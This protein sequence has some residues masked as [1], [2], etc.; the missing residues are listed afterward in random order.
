[1]N[2]IW[3]LAGA[4]CCILLPASCEDE[5]ELP[6]EAVTDLSQVPGTVIWHSAK[7]TQI[8]PGS[9]SIC[10]LPDGSYVASCDLNSVNPPYAEFPETYVF[11]SKDKGAT[12]EKTAELVGHFW[13]Q[14]FVHNGELYSMGTTKSGGEVVIRKSSDG[15]HT[16]SEPKDSDTGLLTSENNSHCAPTPVIVHNGR[17]WRAMEDINGPSGEW[18]VAFRTYMMSAPAD[19]DLLKAS[20]WT[21]S[22][23]LPYDSGYLGGDFK[24]WL[25]GNAVVTP[26]GKIVNI[27]R[28]NYLVNS[29]ELASI[30]NIS[31]DGTSASFDPETGFIDFPGGCKKFSIRKD[32]DNTYWS[33]ANYV[34]DSYKGGNTERTRN[35]VALVSSEDLRTWTVNA[36][37]LHHPDVSYHGFH[38]IDFQFDGEDIIFTA[39]TAF[40]DGLGGASSQHDANL[41]TFHRIENYKDFKTPELWTHL[42]PEN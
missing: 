40:D 33:L 32:S 22:N 31:D 30:V 39:R 9:P 6:A 10:I 14:L 42:M 11:V 41:F 25:E 20:N 2:K 34:P 38:Y 3:I 8:Y 35:T 26:D 19:S 16:W 17:I 29:D 4:L 18:G 24:G 21:S 36:I 12:W 5:F 28:T 13:A 23:R 27:L 37:V 7:R 15:G 1:M